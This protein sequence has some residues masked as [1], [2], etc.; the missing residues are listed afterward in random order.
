MSTLNRQLKA[1]L[2]SLGHVAAL[3]PVP[4]GAQSQMDHQMTVLRGGDVE[5]MIQ[6]VT[7][8]SP[9]GEFEA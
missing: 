6:E 4:S 2:P 9:S 1:E 7:Q 3:S 8:L 5:S